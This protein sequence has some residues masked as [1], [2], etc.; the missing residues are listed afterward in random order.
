[1]VKRIAVGTNPRGIVFSPDGRRAYVANALDDTLTVIET[2]GFTVSG[3]IDL[4]GPDQI[5]ETRWGER[6]FH[7]AA[8]TFGR[9][10][11]CRSCHP[12]GHVNGLTFDIEPDGLGMNPVDNRTLR[13]I[14]D[15]APFKWEGTNPT[16]RRQCGPRLAVFFTRL[17][18]YTPAEL[19]ALVRY[20][21]TIERPPNRYRDADGL[22]PAQRRGQ[23]V[24]Q[25]TRNNR[26]EL[27]PAEQRCTT[28]HSGPTRT[29]ATRGNVG[30]TMWFDVPVDTTV[31]DLADVT[32]D[33]ERY[34]ELG[35]YYFLDTG[36]PTRS[37]DAPHLTNIYDSAPYLH[38]GA[39]P[40]LEEIWT[41]FDVVRLHGAVDDLTRR[42]FNDLIA[43]LKTL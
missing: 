7:S 43:Y 42:Q 39:A 5:T 18:P 27:I 6:L 1:V 21:A 4:G 17:D 24:F 33:V 36:T 26:N 25:R 30:T 32:T 29:A 13:G 14:L 38:N 16:L 22:T 15:T 37:W 2:A 12:D 34:G 8:I 40:S 20:I 10:F 11:S 23:L 41:R 19:T 35:L 9:Q 31:V 3:T 28:C